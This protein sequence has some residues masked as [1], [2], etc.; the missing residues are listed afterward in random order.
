VLY[1]AWWNRK[2]TEVGRRTKSCEE[3]IIGGKFQSPHHNQKIE[4]RGEVR[5]GE[6]PVNL[7]WG[8][9]LTLGKELVTDV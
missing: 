1:R 7:S 4:F 6:K 8:K 5:L 9:N 2:E 3:T